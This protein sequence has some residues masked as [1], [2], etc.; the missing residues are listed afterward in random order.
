MSINNAAAFARL[1]KILETDMAR[2]RIRSRELQYRMNYIRRAMNKVHAM[3]FKR[4][5][6][7]RTKHK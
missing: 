6:C 1:M 3:R 4:I 2:S 7:E 5:R